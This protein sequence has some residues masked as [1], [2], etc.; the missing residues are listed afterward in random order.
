[1]KIIFKYSIN[2]ENTFIQDVKEDLLIYDLK[3]MINSSFT[4]RI[5]AIELYTQNH[6]KMNDN[7]S[8]KFYK[9]NEN[10]IVNIEIE[11]NYINVL[12]EAF[13]NDLEKI[14]LYL[15]MC[16]SV[17]MIKKMIENKTKINIKEQILYMDNRIL[18]DSESI[19]DFIQ[20]TL[21]KD[22][23][24][25][26]L[27]ASGELTDISSPRSLKLKLLIKQSGSKFKLDLDFSFNYMKS[28]KKI[29]WDEEAPDCRE[30]TDGLCLMC[31][32]LNKKCKFYN[33]MYIHNLGK[34]I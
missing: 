4:F 27:D 14:M 8:F 20:I 5:D 32:C 10:D 3:V 11:K 12:I 17:Y 34:K 18:P 21:N 28:L 25:K 33:Q 15:S 1:M 16:T 29:N 13:Q 9:I 19:S 6:I 23:K 26:S 7:C 2:E 24:L 22:T 30:I 31:Y